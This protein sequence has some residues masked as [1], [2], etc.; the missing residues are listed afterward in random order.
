M[1]G[2]TKEGIAKFQ[3]VRG[4]SPND[5]NEKKKKRGSLTSFRTSDKSRK[6]DGDNTGSGGKKTNEKNG[7]GGGEDEGRGGGGGGKAGVFSTSPNPNPTDKKPRMSRAATLT[8]PS[9]FESTE[10][11]SASINAIIS[12]VTSPSKKKITKRGS[13]TI[14]GL[15]KA[16]SAQ[17]SPKGDDGQE[18]GKEKE[19][20]NKGKKEKEKRKRKGRK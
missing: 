4:T 2:K 16:G 3:S 19:E 11:N 10:E 18:K 8:N 13:G 15:K 5:E 17:Y 7:E 9:Y 6:A 20:N 14:V 1:S 12:P